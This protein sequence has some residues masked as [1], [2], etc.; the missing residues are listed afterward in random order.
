MGIFILL[1]LLLDNADIFFLNDKQRYIENKYGEHILRVYTSTFVVMFLKMKNNWPLETSS[2]DICEIFFKL[3]NIGSGVLADDSLKK[4]WYVMLPICIV[5]I[6]HHGHFH[7]SD[8]ELLSVEL[9][10]AVHPQFL[11]RLCGRW[12][13]TAG[14]GNRDVL[15]F[16]VRLLGRFRTL[17]CTSGPWSTYLVFLS[18]S[19]PSIKL[20]QFL[21]H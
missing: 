17:T 21:L 8:V 15:G 7:P 19:F 6:L 11:L 1:Q 9:G 4:H 20:R 10:G 13:P 2:H 3:L 16:G 14:R 5:W 12:Q 18:L